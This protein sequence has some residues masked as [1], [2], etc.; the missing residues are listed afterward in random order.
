MFIKQSNRRQFIKDLGVLGGIAFAATHV[1]ASFADDDYPFSSGTQAPRLRVPA[2]ACDCHHHIYDRAFPYYDDRNL[3]TASVEDYRRIQ[4]RLGLTRSVV[5]QPS[6]YAT[7]NR[8]LL[9]ALAKLGPQSRGIAVVDDK[10]EMAELRRLHEQGVRGIRFNLGVG[11]ATSVDMIEPLSKM[12]ADLGWHIEIHTRPDE[13]IQMEALLSQLPVQ[14]VFDHFGRIPLPAGNDHPVFKMIAR[15]IDKDRAWVKVSGAYQDSVLGGPDYD[16]V[17][18]LA[19]AMIALAPERVVWGT[20]WPHPS[21][22][23]KKKPM[24]DDASMF[25]LLQV[26]AQND[27]MIDK[28]LVQNPAR[29]YGF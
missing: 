5:I 7:D 25:D 15:L 26:W 16:D 24:P 27:V 19:R 23:S 1:L 12:I 8:C 29:L 28:I 14:V 22:Q 13:L 2:Q 10:V 9:A 21:L 11:S 3:P 4:K 17:K 20:D 6:S 18:D